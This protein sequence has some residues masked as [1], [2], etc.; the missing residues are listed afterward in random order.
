LRPLLTYALPVVSVQALLEMARVYIALIDPEGA[1]AVLAQT[2]DILQQRPR[3][4][5]LPAAATRLQSDVGQLTRTAAGGSALTEAELRLVP[6]LP[7]HLSFPGIGERLF[8]SRHTVKTHAISLYRKL[9][10]SSRSEA[11][12]RMS[13]LG[14]HSG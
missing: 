4:G 7:T 13:E 6:L 14:M 12:A 5:P 1:R 3:L 9:G 10:V 2:R 11:V 8:I